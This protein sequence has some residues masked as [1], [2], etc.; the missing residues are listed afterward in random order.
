MQM[1]IEVH[2]GKGLALF[3][4]LADLRPPTQ[5]NVDVH[6]NG[7]ENGLVWGSCSSAL[8]YRT[9]T[10]KPIWKGLVWC[11]DRVCL[12]S[13][14]QTNVE[15]YFVKGL[16]LAWDPVHMRSPIQENVYAYFG[17]GLALFWDPVHPRSPRRKTL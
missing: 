2:F 3:G 13:F 9:K 1:K 7:A 14:I 11:E 5:T 15:I 6:S 10:L 16:A 4:D 8:D 12:R 17:K